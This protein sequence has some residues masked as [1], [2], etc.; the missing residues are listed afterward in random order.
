VPAPPGKSSFSHH[1]KGEEEGKRAPFTSSP[2]TDFYQIYFPTTHSSLGMKA[3]LFSRDS[4]S[5]FS[6]LAARTLLPFAT[7][8][9]RELFSPQVTSRVCKTDTCFHRVA[10]N[11]CEPT[12]VPFFLKNPTYKG[13]DHPTTLC[14]RKKTLHGSRKSPNFCS[15]RT[16]RHH[17]PCETGSVLDLFFQCA[18]KLCYPRPINSS[19][20]GS[21][22]GRRG[23]RRRAD[24]PLLRLPVFFNKCMYHFHPK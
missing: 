9:S 20:P 23:A 21:N 3:L 14:C 15:T 18:D 10:Y 2:P 12:H 1:R 6:H 4:H 22:L 19:R 16:Q 13:Q 8:V 5:L 17:N 7:L 11:F 24:Q